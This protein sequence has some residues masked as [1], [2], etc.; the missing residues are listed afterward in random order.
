MPPSPTSVADALAGLSAPL[1][2]T[3]ALRETMASPKNAAA[4]AASAARDESTPVNAFK[5]I[6]GQSSPGCR[7]SPADDWANL[8]H[9]PFS[10]FDLGIASAAPRGKNFDGAGPPP[11]DDT[12]SSG[13]A[14]AAPDETAR[15]RTRAASTR[16]SPD[17]RSPT[18]AELDAPL[19]ALG[20]PFAATDYGFAFNDYD[21]DD[22]DDVT[23]DGR[24]AI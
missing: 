7:P 24:I 18:P 16:P 14:R 12:A 17:R 11:D 20:G 22:D 4:A 9:R 13:R 1:D 2:L 15:R 19:G 23:V 6:K 3:C 8:P 21:G 10:C 5:T